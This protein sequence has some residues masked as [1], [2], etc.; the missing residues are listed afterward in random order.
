MSTFK[1]KVNRYLLGK[2]A[3]PKAVSSLTIS[4][5]SAT[6]ARELPFR[7]L[8]INITEREWY[9]IAIKYGLTLKLTRG[10]YG[11]DM[12]VGQ[13][14][15]TQVHAW[16]RD[17]WSCIRRLL[18]SEWAET[19]FTKAPAQCKDVFRKTLGLRLS[20]IVAMEIRDN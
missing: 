12:A 6:I 7:S 3:P 5:L 9:S 16:M 14:S 10:R 17:R 15:F 18:K 11:L 1:A 2:R 13:V 19:N 20:C 8:R 4:T